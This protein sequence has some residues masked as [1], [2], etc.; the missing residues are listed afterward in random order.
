MRAGSDIDWEPHRGY[1][2]E[3]LLV[4]VLGDQYGIEVDA[5]K[6]VLKLDEAAG[7]LAVWAYDTHKLPLCPLTYGEVLGDRHPTLE[8]LGDEFG[9]LREWRPQVGRRAAELKRTLAAAARGDI[10]VRLALAAAIEGVNRADEDGVR[11]ALDAV[12]A[13]QY[14]RAAHFRVAG[15]DINYRRFFNIN[16]LAGLRIELPEVFE[17]V[18]G[19]VLELLR[20]GAEL[21]YGLRIDHIDGTLGAARI[22]SGSRRTLARAGRARLLRGSREDPRARRE[23]CPSHGPSAARRATSSV[24]RGAAQVLVD[25][26]SEAALT[27]LYRG[28]TDEREPFADVVQFQ[29]SARSCAARWRARSTC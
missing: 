29:R 6:L 28:I 22:S 12:I 11:R 2:H 21:V 25:P 15:D 13:K 24:A 16:D 5:G 17:H 8:N 23:R 20:K 18:H 3:K 19:L 26:A 1:L 4:P 10:N 7:E 14:W 9:A 27:H